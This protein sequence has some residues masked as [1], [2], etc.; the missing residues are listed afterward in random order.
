MEI[1][2]ISHSLICTSGSCSGN[3]YDCIL[4]QCVYEKTNR[5]LFLNKTFLLIQMS[6]VTLQ[7]TSKLS[8]WAD[9]KDFCVDRFEMKGFTCESLWR[10]CGLQ[11]V[12]EPLH[13]S[14]QTITCQRETANPDTPLNYVA[15]PHFKL[16]SQ[17]V[18]FL[19]FQSNMTN[20]CSNFALKPAGWHYWSEWKCILV[21]WV[22]VWQ[23]NSMVL[24]GVFGV[25]ACFVSLVFVWLC[26]SESRVLHS[27]VYC[28]PWPH[29]PD[30][31]LWINLLFP[32][33][34]KSAWRWWLLAFLFFF[35][36]FSMHSCWLG[37][38]AADQ[39]VNVHPMSLTHNTCGYHLN[40][41]PL[42]L[43][44]DS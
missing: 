28:H 21:I 13:Q 9:I 4:Y 12:T 42:L 27:C 18:C 1:L 23:R 29:G 40:S 17:P 41:F 20:W 25:R 15:S 44:C 5:T 32:W 26:Q 34:A 24:T 2:T 3:C 6:N 37:Q 22:W 8:D 35:N 11:S 30:L 16:N 19:E 36:L 14:Q 10:K 43:C 38:D 33:W 39:T 7:C 31:S